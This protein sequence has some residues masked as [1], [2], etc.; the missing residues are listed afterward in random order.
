[1][2][3]SRESQCNLGC[4]GRRIPMQRPLQKARNQEPRGPL[5]C[6]PTRG[7]VP[8][9]PSWPQGPQF[10][11]IHSYLGLA[12]GLFP[13]MSLVSEWD[14]FRGRGPPW[15]ERDGVRGGQMGKPRSE[16]ELASGGGRQ[17]GPRCGKSKGT[18]MI[19]RVCPWPQRIRTG[20]LRVSS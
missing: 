16:Q 5:T 3:G 2:K 8:D 20:G 1:M 9:S 12:V 14:E 17:P 18:L 15:R 7:L 10:F 4:E 13:L 19:C 6:R 11:Q